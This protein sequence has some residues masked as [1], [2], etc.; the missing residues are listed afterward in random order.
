MFFGGGVVNGGQRTSE[1]RF[2]FAAI[3]T[4]RACAGTSAAIHAVGPARKGSR[5][6]CLREALDA[7]GEALELLTIDREDFL[8]TFQGM[9]GW[10][11]SLA[12]FRTYTEAQQQERGGEREAAAVGD[13]A[14]ESRAHRA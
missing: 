13:A 12:H 4:T 8:G 10:P 3:P 2:H 5:G 7:P 1:T 6:G 11:L 9:L 14:A